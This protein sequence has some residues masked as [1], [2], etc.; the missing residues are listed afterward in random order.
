MQINISSL[1]KVNVNENTNKNGSSA[2]LHERL[3]GKKYCLHDYF[4]KSNMR[5]DGF[6]YNKFF[7]Y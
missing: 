7:Q 4:E 5:G 2:N 3:K 6:L 1:T